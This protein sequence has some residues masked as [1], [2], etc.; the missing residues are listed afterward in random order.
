MVA[1][2]GRDALHVILTRG[3]A[4]FPDADALVALAKEP[5]EKSLNQLIEQCRK[6]YNFNNEVLTKVIKRLDRSILDA[7]VALVLI[8]LSVIVS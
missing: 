7:I 1:V 6:S 8:V 2:S 4:H 5:P 3:Y